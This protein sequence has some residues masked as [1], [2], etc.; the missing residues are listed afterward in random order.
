LEIRSYFWNSEETLHAVPLLF[1]SAACQS[2]AELLCAPHVMNNSPSDA[3][4]DLASAV[5]DP[6]N[7]EQ[8]SP[9][10]HSSLVEGLRSGHHDK[11]GV[12]EL[13]DLREIWVTKDGI[14]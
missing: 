1:P 9:P 14:V 4:I 7:S 12:G 6:N 11:I 3:V 5:A 10:S 13:R 2:R 8:L